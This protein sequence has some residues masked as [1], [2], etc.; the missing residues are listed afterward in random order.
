MNCRMRHTE[1]SDPAI[2]KITLFV[3]SVLGE[4]QF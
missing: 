1:G 3:L 4:L 2:A